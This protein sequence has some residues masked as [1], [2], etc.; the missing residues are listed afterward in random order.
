MFKRVFYLLLLSCIL[1]TGCGNPAKADIPDEITKPF[2]SQLNIKYGD[3]AATAY[4]MRQDPANCTLVFDSPDSLKEMAF[5]FDKESVT[6][7]YKEMQVTIDPK[8][9]LGG[10]TIRLVLA[11]INQAAEGEGV[12]ATYEDNVLTVTG[13]SES[14]QFILTLD[15]EK[16][17][18]LTLSIPAEKLEVEFFNFKILE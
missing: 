10:A 2:E 9:T 16:G 4:F 11:A 13:E 8:S 3:I 15:A 18:I 6:V 5:V 17:N 14:G 12:L 7:A 1:M